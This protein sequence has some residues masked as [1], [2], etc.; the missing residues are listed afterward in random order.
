MPCSLNL[1][2]SISKMEKPLETINIVC[3]VSS[4]SYN[5]ASVAKNP[6]KLSETETSPPGRGNKDKISNWL[7]QHVKMALDVNMLDCFCM[8]FAWFPAA[9]F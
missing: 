7:A 2:T 1:D 8:F 4:C 9:F 3:M 5:T 6:E